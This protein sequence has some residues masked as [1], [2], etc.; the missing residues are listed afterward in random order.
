MR[1]E[2]VL[3]RKGDTKL[4]LYGL[5]NLRDERLARLFQTP[6]CVEW[7]VAW[8]CVM[9]WCGSGGCPML[10]GAAA[11][12]C[13]RAHHGLC[14]S[15]PGSMPVMHSSGPPACSRGPSVREQHPSVSP[16]PLLQLLSIPP[17]PTPTPH[18]P[19]MHQGAARGHA[20]DFTGGL[21]QRLCAA[22]EPC[23]AHAG[24]GGAGG[25]GQLVSWMKCRSWLHG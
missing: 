20:R 3:L 10:Q 1:I 7:W 2:P 22:P 12:C 15:Q 5:G 6:G 9:V 25:R 16:C 14:T 11:A 17:H 19:H 13:K 24:S 4:A 18:L 21:V 23:C 8:G